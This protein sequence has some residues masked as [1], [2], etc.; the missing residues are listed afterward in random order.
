MAKKIILKMSMLFALV[1]VFGL[2]KA[3]CIL[4][5][6]SY[7]IVGETYKHNLFLATKGGKYGLVN[8]SGKVVLKVE[9]DSIDGFGEEDYSSDP[10]AESNKIGF[11]IRKG[12]KWGIADKKGKVIVPVKYKE[13]TF[14]Y[15]DK[16]YKVRLKNKYGL[17]DNK[18][19][20]VLK[21]KY[22]DIKNASNDLNAVTL[23]AKYGFIDLK[24]K[25]V[26]KPKY[27][28][29]GEYYYDKFGAVPLNR[30][31]LMAVNIGAKA[32]DDEFGVYYKTGGKWGFINKKGK[33]VIPVVYD[34]VLDF[35]N[36]SYH[37]YG[38]EY[39]ALKKDNKWTFV[40]KNLKPVSVYGSNEWEHLNYYSG[41]DGLSVSKDGTA[42]FLD[43]EGKLI[44]SAKA[45]II[46][47]YYS[48]ENLAFIHNVV[49]GSN[50]NEETPV[51]LVRGTGEV[52]FPAEYEEI[53]YTGE[54]INTAYLRKNGKSW[55]VK[56]NGERLIQDDYD[57]ISF[58]TAETSNPLKGYVLKKMVGDTANF[59]YVDGYGKEITPIQYLETA[60]FYD[61]LPAVASK[62]VNGNRMYGLLDTNFKEIIAFEYESMQ[63]FFE[64][65]SVVTKTVDGKVR[66]GCINESGKLVIPLEYDEISYFYGGEASAVKN[67]KSG[68]IDLNGNFKEGSH[69]EYAE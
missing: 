29:Y 49:K 1:A 24:G 53:G 23:N 26:V 54:G 7:T 34:E 15:K 56:F 12:T 68:V 36:S 21:I 62:L 48:D 11:M 6:G 43:I 59:G 32:E 47:A 5:A 64:G 44:V 9:Y 63:E 25:L 52:I 69:T 3:E 30:F 41:Q 40:G 2:L 13:A 38:R 33:E 16:L 39:I 51:G 27:D 22:D 66:Y 14:Y 17:V 46:S 65:Y 18:G 50:G 35:T 19:K 67:G 8:K 55:L 57:S 42:Y 10:V 31:K 20:V 60:Y 45:D 37:G 4:A 61:E 58:I 28:D